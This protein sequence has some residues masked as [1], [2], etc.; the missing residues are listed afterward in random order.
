MIFIEK[1]YYFISEDIDYSIIRERINS[2]PLNDEKVHFGKRAVFW[3][4]FNE[5]NYLKTS[6]HKYLIKESFYKAVTIRNGRTFMK[7]AELL[8]KEH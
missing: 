8:D 7:I 2:M 6:Y 5:K 3:G 4:K 1:M